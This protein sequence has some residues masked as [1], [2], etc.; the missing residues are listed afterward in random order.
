MSPRCLDYLNSEWLRGEEGAYSLRTAQQ[1]L[2][3]GSWRGVKPRGLSVIRRVRPEKTKQAW[4]T[5]YLRCPR[6][7]WLWDCALW[8]CS[9]WWCWQWDYSRVTTTGLPVSPE[10]H[11]NTMKSDS[12]GHIHHHQEI[13]NS[14]LVTILLSKLAV[15]PS[16]LTNTDGKSELITHKHAPEQW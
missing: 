12:W 9:Q 10:V 2:N 6:Y 8:W 4:T 14:V 16:L 11:T 1:C 7:P 13:S 15:V 5:E 3:T